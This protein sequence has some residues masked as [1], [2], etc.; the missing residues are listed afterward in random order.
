ML[1]LLTQENQESMTMCPTSLV[2]LF[3]RRAAGAVV[4]MTCHNQCRPAH[5]CNAAQLADISL[6]TLALRS[7]HVPSRHAARAT[8]TARCG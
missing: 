8:P 1:R 7:T 3:A 2:A 4:G 5:R 6:P